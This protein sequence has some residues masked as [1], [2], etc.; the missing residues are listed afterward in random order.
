MLE[1]KT[2]PADLYARARNARDAGALGESEALA[3][4]I[5]LELPANLSAR[6]LLA[7]LLLSQG[8]FAEGWENYEARFDYRVAIGEPAQEAPTYSQWKAII[9]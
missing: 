3:R 9:L 7:E 4:E 1:K 5:L 8:R 6:M 2:N